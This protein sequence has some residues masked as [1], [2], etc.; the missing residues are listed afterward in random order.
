[1][2]NS[3]KMFAVTALLLIAIVCCAMMA[4]CTPDS[5][6]VV[7]HEHE[8]TRV[9]PKA[10]TCLDDGNREYYVCNLCGGTYADADGRASL[11]SEQY[12]IPA[13]GHK[14]AK[15]GEKKATCY[16]EGVKEHYEC[17]NCGLLFKDALGLFEI[18]AP[19]RI[20]ATSHELTRVAEKAAVGFTPGWKEHYTCSNCEK[21][22]KDAAAL[23]ETTADELKIAPELTNFE[24]K[25]AFTPAANIYNGANYISATYV[26]VDGLPATELTVK[27]GTPADTEAYAWIHETVGTTI[28]QGINLRI[29]TLSGKEKKLS[30]TV[31]NHGP[32]TVSFRYYSENYGD[33][34]GVDVVVAAGETKTVE[35]MIN[36][37]STLGCNFPIKFLDAVNQ[38]TKLTIHG[39][40]YCEGEVNEISIYKDAAKK[41]FKVGDSFTTDGLVI[42]AKGTNYDEVVIANYM[43]DLEEGYVF[44]ADDVGT[45]TVIVAFGEFITSYEITIEA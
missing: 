7:T 10:A 27:A 44:T 12:L 24:Y 26:E 2:N 3:K 11:L 42:K 6:N 9:A 14:V 37:G 5:G 36:P 34:G 1:M 35:F 23:M 41:T 22:F 13:K 32:E 15:H 25:I 29:P 16:A 39:F 20:P 18:S 17:R 21:I 45:K 4:G 30:L 28:P 19:G 31:T 43:T 38:E 33:K 8:M 40:F